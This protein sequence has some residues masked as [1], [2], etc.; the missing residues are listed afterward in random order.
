MTTERQ[1]EAKIDARHRGLIIG[2]VVGFI[3]TF[4]L[5]LNT[6]TYDKY[7]MLFSFSIAFAGMI[8]GAFVGVYIPD[9]DIR[10]NS[11]NNSLAYRIWG[12]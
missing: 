11:K 4:L 9:A 8:I 12:G 6:E 3:G 10:E 7:G 5:S 2:I 1:K